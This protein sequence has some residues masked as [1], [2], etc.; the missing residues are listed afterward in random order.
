MG[1][2]SFLSV[3]LASF[4]RLGGSGGAK[5]PGFLPGAT[6]VSQADLADEP[7]LYPDPFENIA[8]I[9]I[10]LCPDLSLLR[11]MLHSMRRRARQLG[12]DLR[13]MPRWGG[14]RE[15]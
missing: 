6:R 3:P 4:G 14:R 12:F 11:V 13:P 15:G 8:R 1:N 10:A 9:K 2:T 5:P 7:G